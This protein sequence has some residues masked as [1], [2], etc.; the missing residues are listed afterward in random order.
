MVREEDEV[1]ISKNHYKHLKQ[2]R[3]SGTKVVK[4]FL[5]VFVYKNQVFELQRFWTKLGQIDLD[6]MEVELLDEKDQVELP[7][8]LEVDREVTNDRR[9]SSHAIARGSLS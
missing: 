4:K 9:Y 1:L 7:P 3:E 6:L 2:F 5:H 8:F